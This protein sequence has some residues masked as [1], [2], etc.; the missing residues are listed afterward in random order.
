M[1]AGKDQLV[2]GAADVLLEMSRQLIADLP[3]KRHG[4]TAGLRLRRP[5]VHLPADLDRLLGHADRA[6][7]NV[8]PTPAE[9]GHLREPQ[10]AVGLQKHE[11]PVSRLDDMGEATDLLRREEP[12]LLDLDLRQ[13]HLATRRDGDEAAVNGCTQDLAQVGLTRF[14]GQVGYVVDRPERSFPRPSCSGSIKSVTEIGSSQ[15]GQQ[16]PG[17]TRRHHLLQSSHRC[18][19][20]KRLPQPSHS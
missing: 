12:H 8:D 9:S 18:S 3:R 10:T 4:P 14:D 2:I 13:R 5:E 11:R 1:W 7:E 17:P 6:P 16:P 15:L 19:P 20:R